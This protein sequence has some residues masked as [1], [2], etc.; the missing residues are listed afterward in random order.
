[1][2]L[3]ITT[4]LLT[5]IYS[6]GLGQSCSGPLNITLDGSPTGLPLEV[7]PNVG[8][9]FCS[10][11]EEGS[12]SLE[13]TGGTP[14][15]SCVWSTGASDEAL[16]NLPVGT[17]SVTVTDYTNCL[18]VLSV[19]VI[20]QHPLNQQL[21]LAGYDCC[22]ECYL[23]DGNAT[24]LFQG[25]DYFLYVKD[26][27]DNQ[28]IGQVEAC[29]IKDHSP[30]QFN[31]YNLLS[32]QWEVYPIFHK[33]KLRLFFT[34][35]ELL[36]LATESNYKNINEQVIKN[37]AVH[38]FTGNNNNP[39]SFQ[40]LTSYKNLT[41]EKYGDDDIWYVEFSPSELQTSKSGYALALPNI[42][43]LPWNVEIAEQDEIEKEKEKDEKLIF[44][45][46][47]T[48]PVN[49]EIEILSLTDKDDF[50]G[51][52]S[53]IDRDGKEIHRELFFDTSL[54]HHKIDVS[55]YTEGLYFLSIW[56]WT[57]NHRNVIKFV[58]V[59]S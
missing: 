37:L 10:D 47:K 42:D 26:E 53:I 54:D 18:K 28:D 45:S 23:S 40:K 6:I 43:V 24:F 25:A 32:R 16:F 31:D 22:G 5:I 1:M 9:V 56:I 59:K 50:H 34:E 41:L 21:Y 48:N 8:H 17:Y 4:I 12:I 7:Q 57:E 36:E 55:G 11:S 39:D 33:S 52:I 19:N 51:T 46:I 20:Q 30:T 44:H 49:K 58:K 38:H 15:Y 13:I 29:L 35:D 2:R 14:N 3:G 27:I